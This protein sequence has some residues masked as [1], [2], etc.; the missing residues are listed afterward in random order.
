MPEDNGKQNPE[1]PYTDKYQKHI[2]CSYGYKLGEDAAYNFVNSMIEECKYCSDVMKNHF[3]KEFVMTKED[4]EDLKNPTKCLICD[5]DY[6]DNYV[7]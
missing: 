1:E 5:N 2:T 7:K 4:N 3:N 6:V